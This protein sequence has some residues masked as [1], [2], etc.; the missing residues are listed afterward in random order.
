[1]QINARAVQRLRSGHLWIYAG[2]VVREPEKTSPAI[3][4]VE[5]AAGNNLGYAFYS[6]QSQIR[7]RLLS[8]SDTPPTAELF[9]TRIESAVARRRLLI[10]EGS[11]CRLVF[12]EGDMLPAVIVDRYDRYLVLQTLSFGADVLKPLIADTLRDL[13]KPS[14]IMERNDVRA[15]ALEGLEQTKGFLYGY[16]PEEVEIQEGGVRFLVD[17]RMG[18]KTGFFLDQSRNRISGRIYASG[19]ALDCFT[20][21]GAFALHFAQS[22]ESVLAVDISADSLET[23]ERNRDLNKAGNVRFEEGNVFDY[24]R[25]LESSGQRFNTICLDPP[26]FAKNRKALEGARK[27]YKEINLRAIKLLEPEGVLITSSCSYHMPE[28]N[29]FKLVC[30]AAR[31]AHRY[32]QIIE[33]RGQSDDHPAL[34]GMPETKYLKCFV[35]RIL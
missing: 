32:V 23:A 9:R 24:L 28:S 25:D 16:V 33:M 26:A 7:L 5:D 11:A 27:G 22:C 15:R 31:D 34:A 29:F 18:Q 17:M 2:D 3:I 6:R 21:T 14:G 8:R 10:R 13:L 1:M 19:R 30:E 20:N 35:L 4:K 12:G